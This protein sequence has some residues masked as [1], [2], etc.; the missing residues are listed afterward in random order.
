ML[1]CLRI[2]ASRLH[3]D[4]RGSALPLFGLSLVVVFGFGALAVNG[5]R[6]YAPRNALKVTADAA[7][8]AGLRDLPDAAAAVETAREVAAANMPMEQHG[9]VL[10]AADVEVGVWNPDTRG[11][12]ATNAGGDALRV[13]ARRASANGNPEIT[14]LAGVLGVDEVDITAVATAV[15]RPPAP[16]CILVLHPTEGGALTVWGSAKL[17]ARDCVI[18]DNSSAGNAVAV[19]GAG[20]IEARRTLVVG[21]ASGTRIAPPAETGRPPVP[22]PD[23]KSVG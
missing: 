9:E 5:S 14:F 16:V 18:Q 3:R 21:G 23:R 10:R 11:F 12:T 13:T 2:L 15:N 6:L 7:A 4:E 20:R 8:L 22:D 1:S 19:G 17:V